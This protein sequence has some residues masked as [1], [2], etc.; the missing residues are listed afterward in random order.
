MDVYLVGGALRDEALGIEPRE[1]DWCVVGATPED[2]KAEGYRQVGRDFPVF[3]HPESGEEYALA[4]TERKT[5]PGYRGFEFRTSPDVTI[6][7]DLA[8]RDLTINAMARDAEGKLLDP[9]N[10][11][12]DLE[13]RVL[14][15]V[16]DAFVEDP[17]RIL[18]TARFA[19]RFSGLGFTIAPETIDLM[20]RMVE[21]GEANALVP[22]RVWKETEH[23]LAGPSP[24]TFFL[25]LRECGA[26]AAVF[27]E[28][29]AL[30]GVPQPEKWHPEI[31]CGVHTMMVLEQA[32]RL[33][34]EVDVRFAALVHDLGKATTRP[35]DL[36]S[37]PG[38]ERRSM[39]LIQGLAERFPVPV[40]CRELALRVAEFHGHC[41]KALELR[42]STLLRVLE[43]IDAFRR[44]ER[45]LKF[46]LACEADARGRTGLEDRPYPQAEY[47]QGALAVAAAVTATDVA[48]G[49][50]PG[51]QIGEAL[52][53]KRLQAIG[54]WRGHARSVDAS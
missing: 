16:S 49:D 15:H 22:H 33:S 11:M 29:D 6:E 47:F 10:G 41:H 23:A 35:A 26:L 43:R 53:R 2:L 42:A 50:L 46:L 34:P 27:P 20:R 12:R 7:E 52:R 3:L 39:R 9:F 1:R 45:F 18:R 32:T 14:R 54:A 30:F 28:I 4:R 21:N 5:G 19:A 51:P 31:D 37:H 24:Q 44:P 25:A 36:P 8:R 48:T 13:A 17:V 40:A 38:H